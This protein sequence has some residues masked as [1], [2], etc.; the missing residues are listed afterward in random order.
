VLLGVAALLVFAALGWKPGEA[1]VL[2]YIGT[3][4]IAFPFSTSTTTELMGIRNSV[5][6]ARTAGVVFLV[7]AAFL[8]FAR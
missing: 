8:L 7:G 1:A 2:A 3:I 6:F 4:L 5:R